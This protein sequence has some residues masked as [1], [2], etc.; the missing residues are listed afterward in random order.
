MS[1]RHFVGITH[2]SVIDRY[3]ARV[4]R[5]MH[6]YDECDIHSSVVWWSCASQ[7]RSR[8]EELDMGPCLKDRRCRPLTGGRGVLVLHETT[9]PA[10]L[11]EVLPS[12]TPLSLSNK[13]PNFSQ[14]F[15]L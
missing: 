4:F 1:A 9:S 10:H 8:Y 11:T 2:L 14:V 3:L 13:L 5:T 6:F 7:V 15:H 12:C